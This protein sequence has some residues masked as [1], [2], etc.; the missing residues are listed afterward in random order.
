[1][2][3]PNTPLPEAMDATGAERRSA[4]CKISENIETNRRREKAGHPSVPCQL[5]G[6]EAQALSIAMASMAVAS[7]LAQ[8]RAPKGGTA[9]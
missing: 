9:Q 8:S 4:L 7:I 1:M 5:T 6:E 2:I 3:D